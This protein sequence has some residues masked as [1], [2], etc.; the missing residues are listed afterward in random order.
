[1]SQLEQLALQQSLSQKSE[2]LAELEEKIG[3]EQATIAELVEYRTRMQSQKSSGEASVLDDYERRRLE[4]DKELTDLAYQSQLAE[5]ELARKGVFTKSRG[6]VKNLHV[7]PGNQVNAGML[8]AEIERT[9]QMIV[10]GSANKYLMDRLKLGQKVKVTVNERTYEGEVSHV[11]R[12]ASINNNNAV[13]VAFEVSIIN[14]D[15]RIYL[16][17]EAKMNILTNEAE[18]CLQLPREA[19]NA[20]KD[21]EFVYVIENGRV[22][23]KTV[24]VGIISHGIAEIVEGITEKDQVVVRFEDYLEEGQEVSV[25]PAL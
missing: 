19:I 15:D 5:A 12:M 23:K 24:K 25:V 9:D 4:I 17:M 10:I 14:P 3:E 7:M 16:G 18:Q 6:V 21:G 20:N 11:D 13:S 1:M 22:A 2:Y 8:L